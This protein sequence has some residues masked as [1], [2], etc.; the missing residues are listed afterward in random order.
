M[1]VLVQSG[2]S[3]TFGNASV[4]VEGEYVTGLPGR[5]YDAAPDG[6]RFLMIKQADATRAEIVVVQNWLDELAQ[7]VPVP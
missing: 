3:F 1:S 5:Q 7:R 2:P 4:L 6:Q